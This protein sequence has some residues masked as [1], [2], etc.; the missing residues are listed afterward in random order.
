MMETQEEPSQSCLADC[1]QLWEGI[2]V[3]TV[4]FVLLILVHFYFKS[5]ARG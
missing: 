3:N 1:S 5:L 2:H 4:F